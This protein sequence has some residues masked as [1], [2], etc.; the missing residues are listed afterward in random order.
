MN[1]LYAILLAALVLTPA[2]P[3]DE[4]VANAVLAIVNDQVIT[5]RDLREFAGPSLELL[6]QQYAGRPQQLEE[7]IKATERDALDQLVERKLILHEFKT[8]GYN[9]PESIIEDRVR[10]RIR[11]RYGDRLNLTRTLQREGITYET[12]KQRVRE[13]F[14]VAVMRSRNIS[15]EIIISPFKIEK[16]YADNREK[17]RVEDQVKLRVIMINQPQVGPQDTARKMADEIVKKLE[18]GADFAQMASIYSDDSY[19]SKGG[20]RGWVERKILRKEL[21]DPAFTLKPGQRSGVIETKEACYVIL[22]EAA[23]A[24]QV[25][26]LPEMRDE[27]EKNLITQERD[28]LNKAW[29]ERIKAKSFLRF[30]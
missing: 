16:Y 7:R 24:N 6:M 2:R 28:R 25:K 11:E 22:V 15:Q 12:F 4:A 18:E 29:I 8:A 30:F 19:R 3:A 26:T 9:L 27:I 17:Y 13:D 5:Y 10:S 23:Q 21:A 20:D 1:R 14:I